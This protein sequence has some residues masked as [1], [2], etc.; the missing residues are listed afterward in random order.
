MSKRAIIQDPSAFLGF[1]CPPDQARAMVLPVPFEETTTYKKGTRQG[2]GAILEASQQVELYDEELGAEPYLEGVHTLDEF[3]PIAS[4]LEESIAQIGNHARAFLSKKRILAVLGGEHS[5]TVGLVRAHRKLFPNLSV[6]QIDAH[7][8]LRTSYE[9]S[10]YNHACVMN[11]IVKIC[12]SVQVGL[13]SMSVEEAKSAARRRSQMFFARDIVGRVGWHREVLSFL[14]R[15]VYLTFDLDGLDPSIMP[16]VG[17]PEPGGMGWYETLEFLKFVAEN[18]EIVGLDIVELCP[19]ENNSAPDFL[20][21]RL[22][23]KIL[24]Y[25]FASR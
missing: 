24:G 4:D 23:Y 15:Q 20:A 10:P 19:Q 16:S 5:I 12:P 7:A 18:R 14:A 22:V 9:G 13:R 25:I 17:T 11:H 2:P 1:Q 3:S 21:A 6:L 8:D